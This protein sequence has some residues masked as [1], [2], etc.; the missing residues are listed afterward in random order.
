MREYL[1]KNINSKDINNSMSH[2]DSILILIFERIKKKLF[3]C[4]SVNNQINLIR[5]R[6]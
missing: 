5:H 1:Q 2:Y 4:S 6:I 3:I